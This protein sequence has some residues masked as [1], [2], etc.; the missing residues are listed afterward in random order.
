MFNI[1]LILASII[2]KILSIPGR[3]RP[4]PINIFY[5]SHQQTVMRDRQ[6]GSC[7]VSP[8]LSTTERT[9]FGNGVCMVYGYPST[10]GVL[11][12]GASLL[13]MLFL[14]LPRTHTSQRSPS[15]EEEDRFCNLMR[16]TGAKWWPSRDYELE[17]KLGIRDIT[18]RVAD[19]SAGF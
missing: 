1:T 15:A 17:V 8:C 11:N 16:R 18:D 14:S 4:I 5:L 7:P 2:S 19:Q 10:G 13:D 3:L 9:I 12:K 6:D